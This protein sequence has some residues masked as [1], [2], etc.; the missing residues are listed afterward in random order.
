VAATI[1]RA[2]EMPAEERTQRMR[3]LRTR[4]FEQDVR[5]WAESFL[6]AL[7]NVPE[8]L[9]PEYRFA[10]VDAL[11]AR[12][13][14]GAG[15]VELILDYDGTLVPFA[16][17]PDEAAPDPDLMQTLRRLAARE[18]TRVHI[19]T[20]RSRKSI[21]RWLG[22]LDVGI[23]A[24]HGLWYREG[25][26]DRWEMSRPVPIEWKSSLRP[27]LKHFVESTPGSFTEEK[28]AA[29]VWHYRLAEQDFGEYQARELRLLLGELL[30]NAPVE[31]NSANKAVEI[32]AQG[33][34]KADAVKALLAERA[35][36]LVIAIGDEENDEDCY[37]DL[38]D[39]SIT[40]HVNGGASRAD[41]RVAGLTDVRRILRA[42]VLRP[43]LHLAPISLGAG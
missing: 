17:S 19:V 37:P 22:G 4:V 36:S 34:R 1:R 11:T 9:T 6:R 30:S 21:G 3:S 41:Y 12:L 25:Q 39:G 5:R 33:V 27:I 14:D 15:A 8:R 28:T 31:V 24:E 43:V 35:S 38:P 7:R 40:V 16:N 20:G 32:K 13:A 18:D 2:L 10:D 26:H 42:L 23:S 29:I